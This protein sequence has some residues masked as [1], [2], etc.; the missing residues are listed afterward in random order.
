MASPRKRKVG[1][2]LA[3]TLLAQLAERPMYPFEMA[4]VLRERG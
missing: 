3:L 4:S 2:L 1:N